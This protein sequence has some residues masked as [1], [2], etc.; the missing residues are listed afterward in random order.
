MTVMA[1]V[2]LT[3]AIGAYLISSR[4]Q[5]M[6]NDAL[7]KRADVAM[8]LG[9]ACRAFLPESLTSSN[10]IDGESSR[11]AAAAR[12]I[13]ADVRKRRNFA[14]REAALNPLNENNRADTEEAAI[15]QGFRSNPYALEQTG[16]KA[17][18]GIEQF[19]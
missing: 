17:S 6:V 19:Y 5:R 4:E 2:T 8:A 11:S 16:R 13:L 12:S 9:E 15:I 7:R 1:A 14:Y 3:A 18:N 10:H